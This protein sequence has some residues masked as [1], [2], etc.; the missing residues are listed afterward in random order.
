MNRYAVVLKMHNSP[1]ENEPE[2]GGDLSMLTINALIQQLDKIED[3]LHQ[4]RRILMLHEATRGCGPR[5]WTP[6]VV[7]PRE[8]EPDSELE[9]IA[10]NLV[11]FER[12]RKELGV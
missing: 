8:G 5:R 2:E 3:T 12:Q 1:Q 10:R 9:V 6:T 4:I 11:K 7:K